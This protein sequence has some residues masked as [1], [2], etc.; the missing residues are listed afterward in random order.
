MTADDIPRDWVLTHE[1]THLALPDQ[2]REFHWLEEGLATYVEP[3][4]RAQVG[5]SKPD[6][7]WRG[8]IDGLPNGE[9]EDGDEGLDRTHSWGRTYWGGA[10]FCLAADLE[11]RKRT[12]NRKS[13]EDALRGILAAGGSG[14]TRWPLEE[15]L[16]RADLAVGVP[17]LEELHARW[18][19]APVKVDLAKLW[20]ELGVRADGTDGKTVA[21]DDAAP[22]ASVRRAVTVPE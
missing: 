14:E 15:V 4:A 11:I 22:L 18:G 10:L 1:M 12:G 7:V 13:L 17:V 19:T 20:T 8:L 2:R 9:P 21:F 3:I 6:E 16:R 5:T